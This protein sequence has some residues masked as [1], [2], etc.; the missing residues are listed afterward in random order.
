MLLTV[1][2]SA[3]RNIKEVNANEIAKGNS[4]I[5]IT[6]A[7]IIDGNGG[8]PIENGTVLVSNGK[9]TDVGPKDKVKI[10]QGASITDAAGMSLLPGF[11]DA[12]F[13]IDGENDLPGMFLQN[14]VTS[15]R[16]PGAWIETYDSARR[17]GKPQPRM[18]R[19]EAYRA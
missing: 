8:H 18:F 15:V 6:N 10:P 2:V 19:F 3:Q 9:I 11:I 4:V 1:A 17:S 14:G 5:V 12:H 16:D 13:H 7:R